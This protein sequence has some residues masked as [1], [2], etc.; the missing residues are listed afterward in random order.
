MN[1]KDISFHEFSN[2]N[3][4]RWIQEVEKTLKG[5]SLDSLQKETYEG[6]FLKP[7][8]CFE[9]IQHLTYVDDLPGKDSYVR[10]TK[11]SGYLQKGW[12]IAQEIDAPDTKQCNQLLHS[13]LKRGQTM[14]ALHLDDATSTY[15]DADFADERDI[16]KGVSISHLQDMEQLFQ[17]LSLSEY[18]LFINTQFTSLPFI[19][20]LTG[21]CEKHGISLKSLSGTIG[22]DPLGSIA[23]MGVA[24]I[25]LQKMY[26]HMTDI[27]K[28]SSLQENSLKTILVTSHPYH[29]SGANAVQELAYVMATAVEYID[30]CL[31]R[32]LSLKAVVERMTISFSV[33][34][35]LFMEVA[36]LRAFKVL[37][38]N[39][40]RAFKEDEVM[41][42]P[43][44]HAKTSL[45]TKTKYDA[46]T[47]MLR[48][49]VEAFAAVLGGIDA[50]HVSPYDTLLQPCSEFSN[51]IARNTQLI[52]QK[53][54]HLT[55]VIDPAGGSW[56]VESLTNQ[57]AEKAWELFQQIESKGGMYESLKQGFVQ[58]QITETLE[59]RQST[60]SKRKERIVGVTH[61]T[62]LNEQISERQNDFACNRVEAL[63]QYRQ[64]YSTDIKEIDL[65]KDLLTAYKESLLKGATLGSVMEHIKL[66]SER[67]EVILLPIW[68][69]AE[70]FEQL[71][72]RVD[73][74][75]ATRE[76]P[77]TVGVILL[78]N[79]RLTNQRA[80]FAQSF[81][82]SSGMKVETS[83]LLHS[84]YDAVD[85]IKQHPYDAFVVCGTSENYEDVLADI[86]SFV[87]GDNQPFYIVGQP[88]GIEQQSL[89]QAG[90]SGVITEQDN[91]VQVMNQL[92]DQLGVK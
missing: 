36:K 58:S 27:T 12:E 81:V 69:K 15:I 59:K 29:N 38:T 82:Q 72:M 33:S 70:L 71:R 78:S 30:E 65:H 5:K 24:P 88:T 11:A 57:L 55:K 48:G 51:R 41:I 61:Y 47:N 18:P 91:T 87:K 83:H 89:V 46:H 49:T 32:G 76:N 34:S 56:Y 80:D 63:K 17:G 16:G 9:D 20:L 90:L 84:A 60:I 39:V 14:I 64:E 1:V 35:N 79:E 31:K 25:Q 40:I 22:M 7:L 6:I 73:K 62:N 13:S 66:H 77:L 4:E 23:K 85:W 45:I 53:E 67:E 26:D 2:V 75:N 43:F 28:W 86:L 52:L 19:S 3:V 68:R 21:Y 37:W 42:T 74:E 92:L 54:A 10:G 8:Y 50:L 44:I